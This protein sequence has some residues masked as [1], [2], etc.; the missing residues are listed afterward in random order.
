MEGTTAQPVAEKTAKEDVLSAP[1][2]APN[3][4]SD[5]IEVEK[6]KANGET[7]KKRKRHEGETPEEKADRKRQKKEKKE[8][9]EKAAAKKAAKGGK[10]S[11]SEEND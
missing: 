4:T 5:A 6:P 1:P 7:D 11:E 9:K 2:V 3:G 8:R 10:T